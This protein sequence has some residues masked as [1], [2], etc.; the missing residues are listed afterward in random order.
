MKT[1]HLIEALARDAGP[2]PRGI[3]ERR[4]VLGASVGLAASLSLMAAL[5]GVRA[6]FGDAFLAVM[7]KMAFSITAAATA[8]PM[9]LE[10]ARPNIRARHVA[11]PA[12]AFALA[13]I[14]IAFVAFLVTPAEARMGAWLGGGVPECLYRIPLLAIPI[15][16]ALVLAVR[17]LGATRLSL[18]GAAIGAVSGSLAAIAYANCCPMDSALYVASWYLAA[19]L[20][21]AGVGALVL[22]R[23]LKW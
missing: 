11:V 5:F 3:V 13:S 15:A 16:T 1:D 10:L 23:A 21:C 19:I 22:G 20:F 18:V 2:V 9:L 12:I 7:L 6:D 8:T 14:L 4:I 17:G